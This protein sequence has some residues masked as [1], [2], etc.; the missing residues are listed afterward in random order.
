[1]VRSHALVP[2]IRIVKPTD[3]APLRRS[4]S[5]CG[6]IR[7][8]RG[9]TGAL[10]DLTLQL[11]SQGYTRGA[12][13]ALARQGR[14]T[15]SFKLNCSE[16]LYALDEHGKSMFQKMQLGEEIQ[17]VKYEL[18]EKP[19]MRTDDSC[20]DTSHNAG[21]GT[22]GSHQ[23]RIFTRR[24]TSDSGVKFK[25]PT[26]SQ[27]KAAP[28]P[29]GLQFSTTGLSSCATFTDG[30]C[31]LD[32]PVDM[33]CNDESIFQ[34]HDSTTSRLALSA[35]LHEL[36]LSA[37][38]AITD[39]SR[40][41]LTW[42]DSLRAKKT[43]TTVDTVTDKNK[44]CN[45]SLTKSLSC[46][47]IGE[48]FDILGHD[49]HLTSSSSSPVSK[50]MQKQQSTDSLST[51]EQGVSQVGSWDFFR[52]NFS[53]L[54]ANTGSHGREARKRLPLKSSISVATGLYLITQQG[55]SM[56]TS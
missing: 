36:G 53:E 56:T 18:M 51:I 48:G 14:A 28:S 20:I 38:E 9:A 27:R 8:W 3:S 10:G 12:R 41:N 33:S 52:Q 31:N 6:R 7:K 22:T 40:W 30:L 35:S 24:V 11:P 43:R 25:Y 15:G 16:S 21:S 39:F 32:Y 54:E 29:H 19:P 55:I 42:F 46:W 1:M 23:G 44:T 45:G 34:S 2:A 47:N 37:S 13:L 5:M 50:R 4:V 49:S 26:R 17:T